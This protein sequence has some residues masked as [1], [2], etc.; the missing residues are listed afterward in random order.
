MDRVLHLIPQ[1]SGGGGGRSAL[2]AASAS[3][4]TTG[5]RPTIVSLRP[6]P[7]AMRRAMS[8]GGVELIDAPSREDLLDAIARA[9]LVQVHFWNS[10][11]LIELLETDLPPCRVLIWPHVA[12][13]TAPQVIDPSLIDRATLVVATSKRSAD[14]IARL[15]GKE[16]PEVIPPIPGWD[17]VEDVTRNTSGGYNVGYIGTVGMIRL[18]PDFIRISNAARI[19]EARF[20]VCGDGDAS[21]SLPREAAEAGAADRFEFR[22]HV[23]RIGDA[24][25]EFDVFGYPIRPG[26]SASSDL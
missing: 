26:T 2:A 5:M 18:H 6:T 24:L 16:R 3:A 13:H 22:G 4:E 14:V 8:P 25:A 11:E 15:G 12:G 21:R 10:P 20:I 19:P 17:R 9:D 23:D 1:F 7:P